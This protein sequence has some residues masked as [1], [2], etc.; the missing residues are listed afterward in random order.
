[1]TTATTDTKNIIVKLDRDLTVSSATELRR[2]LK[3]LVDGGATEI[4]LG[5]FSVV[6]VSRDLETLFR[7]VGLTLHFSITPA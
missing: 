2:H 1:M 6:N 7:R 3:E 5:K 4:V